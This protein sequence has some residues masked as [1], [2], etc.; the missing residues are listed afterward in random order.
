M[1]NFYHP[2]HVE[3]EPQMNTKDQDNVQFAVF[4]IVTAM[5]SSKG[6]PEHFCRIKNYCSSDR[7]RF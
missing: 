6:N 3:S 4:R 7:A 2:H 1:L 5:L